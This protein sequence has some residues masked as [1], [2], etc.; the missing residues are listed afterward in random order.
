MPAPTFLTTALKLLKSNSPE[1]LTA[2]GV[3]GV[4]TTSDLSGKAS[5]KA[6]K[7]IR[8]QERTEN[9][10]KDPKE[11]LK[12]RTKL[13]WKL[14]IPTAVSGGTT[15]VCIIWAS[16]ASN[17]RTAAAVSAYA[18]TQQAFSEY[19]EKVIEQLNENKERKIRDERAQDIVS[20]NPSGSR[21]VII[22]GKGQNLCCELLT[23]RYFRSDMETLRKAQ[24]DTNAMIVNNYYVTLS[25]FYDF[26]DLPYTSVSSKIGWDSDKLMELIFT[27]TLSE[28]GEPCLAFDYNYT[29][30]LR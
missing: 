23:R 14:Y 20:N 2:L 10:I 16:K 24:N 27:T 19:R 28:D 12:K 11:R 7:M 22:T 9:P 30:P 21:E 25:E 3:A 5:Y 17:H 26:I 15:I 4:V 13:V 8:E 1:I 6:A 29:K 18:V